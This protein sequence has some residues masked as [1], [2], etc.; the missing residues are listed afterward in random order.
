[1]A[2][3]F[4]NLIVEFAFVKFEVIRAIGGVNLKCAY[5]FFQHCNAIFIT[6]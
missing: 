2:S 3:N 6:F 5:C 4:T 1:M